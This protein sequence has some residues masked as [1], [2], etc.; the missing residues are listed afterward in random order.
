MSAS[1]VLSRD[2]VQFDRKVIVEQSCRR[3]GQ[4]PLGA[5]KVYVGC[6]EP[7]LGLITRATLFLTRVRPLEPFSFL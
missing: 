2:V 4:Y 7:P 6:V 5:I 1:R 3:A